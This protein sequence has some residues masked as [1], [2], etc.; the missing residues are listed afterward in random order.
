MGGIFDENIILGTT[1]KKEC[2]KL[3]ALPDFIRI[4]LDSVGISG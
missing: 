1:E 3:D 2:N 4:N